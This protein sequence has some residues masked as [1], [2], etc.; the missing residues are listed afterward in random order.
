LKLRSASTIFLINYVAV[1]ILYFLASLL[2]PTVQN[3][4]LLFIL[5]VVGWPYVTC[6]GLL[7][8]NL[9]VVALMTFVAIFVSLVLQ[10]LMLRDQFWDFSGLEKTSSSSSQNRRLRLILLLQGFTFI[11][12][13]LATLERAFWPVSLLM[14]TSTCLLLAVWAIISRKK[15]NI[16]P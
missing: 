1:G 13:V 7:F 15:Q 8:V 6:I 3:P 4:G 12:I 5:L 14:W 10:A 2:T 16:V 9:P 11:S